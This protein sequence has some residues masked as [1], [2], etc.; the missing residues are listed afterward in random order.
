[1]EYNHSDHRQLLLDIEYYM[2]A[3]GLQGNK[4]QRFEAK[5]FKEEGFLD[6][7]EEQWKQ[8][9]QDSRST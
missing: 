1:M 6:I 5:W 4:H 8:P 3:A 2:A 9:D 7:V